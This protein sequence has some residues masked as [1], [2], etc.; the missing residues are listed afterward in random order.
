MLIYKGCADENIIMSGHYEVGIG[1]GSVVE[2]FCVIVG[3]VYNTWDVPGGP[4]GWLYDGKKNCQ[5]NEL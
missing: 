1:E 3:D 2:M 5:G 4:C